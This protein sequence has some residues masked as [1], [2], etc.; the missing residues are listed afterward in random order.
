MSALDGQ[1]RL[2][3]EVEVVLDRVGR[4]VHDRLGVRPLGD[5]LLEVD[6]GRAG[7]DLDGV[8]GHGRGRAHVGG[9]RLQLHLDLR[10]GGLGLLDGVGA[11][12]GDG[13]AVLE[14]LGVAQDGPIP[15]VAL[16][17]REGDQAGDAVLALDVLVRD[18]L[19]RRRA[20]SR[21]R[22]CQSTGCWRARPSPGP[23]PVAACRAAS[24]GP[25]PGR[26]RAYR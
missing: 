14:D 5:L 26:S 1:V 3:L 22:R 15:A 11:D 8:V 18:H 19:R 7:M 21:L 20:S 4:L 13:V 25:D 17:R 12:D 23:A 24:S 16:V 9:Q 6:V 2:A 10:R